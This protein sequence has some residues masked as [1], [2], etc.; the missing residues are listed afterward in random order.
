MQTEKRPSSQAASWGL[1]IL[2]GIV[3]V[4]I[5][6]SVGGFVGGAAIGFLLAQ[7]IYL[8]SR[9]EALDKELQELKRRPPAPEAAPA[10]VATPAPSPAPTPQPEVPTAT[11]PPITRPVPR[12]DTLLSQ[13]MPEAPSEPLP[14]PEPTAFE[15][16]IDACLAW[17]KRG[18]PL[19]RAGIVILFFGA[20]FLAKYAAEH[21][22]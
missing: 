13:P 5:Q 11:A 1:A 8:R 7:V 15:R 12:V 2:L 21:S 10:R 19:A 4:S 9:T 18:N 22:M 20:A 17:L 3:G 6:Q 14:P 16:G